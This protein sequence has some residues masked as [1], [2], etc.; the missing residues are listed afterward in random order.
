MLSLLIWKEFLI[1]FSISCKSEFDTTLLVEIITPLLSTY[2]KL[3]QTLD[4]M[5]LR[6][7][8]MLVMWDTKSLMNLLPSLLFIGTMTCLY[9]RPFIVTLSLSLGLSFELLT[10]FWIVLIFLFGRFRNVSLIFSIFIVMSEDDALDFDL[11]SK[12]WVYNL[13]VAS[14]S[15]FLKNFEISLTSLLDLAEIGAE[16]LIQIMVWL[17]LYLCS[18]KIGCSW[19]KEKI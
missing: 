12:A 3:A 19:L 10:T 4:L 16:W 9:E 1:Y 14:F 13:F 11:D 18:P 8:L 15:I 17:L 6:V 5:L 7:R 2:I